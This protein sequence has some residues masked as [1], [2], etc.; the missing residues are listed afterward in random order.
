M[1]HSVAML[2]LCALL[3]ISTPLA[4]A[5]KVTDLY[6]VT[7][8]VDSQEKKALSRAM[9]SALRDVVL[10]VTGSY[11]SLD[12]PDIKKA[13]RRPKSYVQQ[14]AYLNSKQAAATD[15]Q[16]LLQVSFQPVSVNTLIR[17]AGLP[18][19][20]RNRPNV[21]IWLA[22]DDTKQRHIVGLESRPEMA[23]VLQEK[24]RRRALPISLP[25][26]DLEDNVALKVNEI[27][28]LKPQRIFS[29]SQRYPSEA[30]LA[31]RVLQTS[32]GQW[33]GSWWFS[34]QSQTIRFDGQGKDMETY[35]AYGI[36]QIADRLARQYAIDP[37]LL[38]EDIKLVLNG[39]NS[40]SAYLAALDYLR[41]V[42]A[43]REVQVTKVEGDR[44][45]FALTI[46]GDLE[47][48]QK[49]I[50]LGKRLQPAQPDEEETE[51]DEFQTKIYYHWPQPKMS[52]R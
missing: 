41:N 21:L 35:L 16:L 51:I 38:D 31:G 45:V 27:W 47:Q 30:I 20:T 13:V 40:Y 18:L 36:D 33:I 48:L 37:Q 19:W 44:M 9:G 14:F 6:R 50:A 15:S 2:F 17:Q 23:S 28:Q 46:E 39:I 22:V 24:A 26:L 43:I 29:A 7:L 5:E 52:A 25:L 42:V 12:N 32:T 49:V 34:Y 10:R 11:E 8:P 1:C 3:V 4:W